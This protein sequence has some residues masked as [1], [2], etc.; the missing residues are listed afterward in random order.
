MCIICTTQVEFI[1]LQCYY[2]LVPVPI[3]TLTAPNTQIVG[4]LLTLECSVTTVRGITSRVDIVWMRNGLIIKRV[5][6]ISFTS[7]TKDSQ[8]YRDIYTVAQLKTSD[9]GTLYHCETGINISPKI[10][11]SSK[12]VILDITSECMSLRSQH[13]LLRNSI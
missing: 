5:D 4:Q 6:S 12:L 1:K 13:E 3:V 11:T 10:T 2:C 8:V 9:G 7:T